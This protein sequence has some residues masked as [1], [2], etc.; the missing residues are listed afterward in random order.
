MPREDNDGHD[1]VVCHAR[2]R[3]PG[4]CLELWIFAG[5]DNSHACGYCRI[6]LFPALIQR[7]KDAEVERD[8][9]TRRR[10]LES[11]LCDLELL[12]LSLVYCE[13]E[14]KLRQKFEQAVA[15]APTNP[16]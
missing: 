8:Y 12:E 6:E 5:R 14:L 13:R 11:H 7:I 9:W 16:P 3:S 2:V 4:I 15:Q 10:A 1:C